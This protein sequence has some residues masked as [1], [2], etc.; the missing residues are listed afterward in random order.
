VRA[1]S[2]DFRFSV[3]RAYE[4]GRGSQRQLARLFGV[5]VSFVQNLLRHYRRTGGVAPKPHKGG[6]QGKIIQYLEVVA[7]LQRQWPD[8]S[9]EEMCE[10]LAAEAHITVSP[11]TMCRARR[12]LKLRQR[13]KGVGG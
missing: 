2:T 13:K 7:R 9:L 4:N 11:A 5:S 1:Y 12:R 10:R 8:A 6:S 3:V